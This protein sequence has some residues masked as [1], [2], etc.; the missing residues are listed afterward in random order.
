[1]EGGAHRRMIPNSDCY[2]SVEANTSVWVLLFENGNQLSDSCDSL[3]SWHL[4][5]A[6]KRSLCPSIPTSN[7]AHVT[8][9]LY[10]HKVRFGDSYHSCWRLYW[11]TNYVPPLVRIGRGFVICLR[12]QRGRGFGGLPH[13]RR[14]WGT[15]RWQ[16][17]GG[18]GCPLRWQDTR[19]HSNV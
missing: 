12:A 1:V 9:F 13:E 19:S 7:E 8:S 5:I 14:G 16:I 4:V 10:C 18:G 17:T 3:L 2:E 15:L 6:L 11:V